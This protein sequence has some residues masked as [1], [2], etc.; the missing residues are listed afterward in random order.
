MKGT[1]SLKHCVRINKT[2]T[3]DLNTS[4]YRIM[5]YVCVLALNTSKSNVSFLKYIYNPTYISRLSE[6]FEGGKVQLWFSEGKAPQFVS[7]HGPE[8]P[9]GLSGSCFVSVPERL[10]AVCVWFCVD[11]EISPL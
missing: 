5:G 11:S 4:V 1:S 7:P 2:V 6:T 8:G 3:L 9:A 10:E